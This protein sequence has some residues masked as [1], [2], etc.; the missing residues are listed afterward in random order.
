MG[1]RRSRLAASGHW[2]ENDEQR[3]G[4]SAHSV[5]GIGQSRE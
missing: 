5:P 4:G 1:Y 2:H 3:K